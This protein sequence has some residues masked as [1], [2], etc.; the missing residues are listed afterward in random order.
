MSGK[1]IAYTAVIALVVVIGF[2]R[3]KTHAPK[4]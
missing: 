2:E 4:A 3:Y 1:A